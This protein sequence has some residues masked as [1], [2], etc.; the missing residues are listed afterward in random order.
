MVD[1]AIGYAARGWRVFPA[2]RPDRPQ[3]WTR[4]ECLCDKP[5]CD[6]PGEHSVEDR[7][8]ESATTDVSTIRAWWEK[9]PW[10]SIGIA[11]GRKSN[12]VG[13]ELEL[14]GG[15]LRE[16]A[17]G[18]REHTP[19]MGHGGV[20][21]YIFEY[22]DFD[23]SNLRFC[24]RGLATMKAEGDFMIVPPSWSPVR[25]PRRDQWNELRW[26][27]DRSPDLCEPPPL[28]RSIHLLAR[29]ANQIQLTGRRTTEPA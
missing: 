25:Y 6:A 15:V 29:F 14:E 3:Y 26:R 20:Q 7:G 17:D 4:N 16:L 18:W 21:T 22:P 5:V 10:A 28:P 19:A 1:W 13:L 9:Y 27:S 8:V 12:I 2:Y 11:L 23:A 24:F